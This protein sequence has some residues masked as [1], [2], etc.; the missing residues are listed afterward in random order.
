MGGRAGLTSAGLYDERMPAKPIRKTCTV[1]VDIV[2]LTV[3][4][5][6]LQI[7]LIDRGLSPFDGWPALPGGFV[8]DEDLEA[9]AERELIEETRIDATRLHLEQLQTYGAPGRDP[10]GRVVAVAYLAL[11][12]NLPVPE[13]GTDALNA[14]WTPVSDVLN[15]SIKL[16][17]DHNVIVQDGVERARSKLEYTTLATA[18]CQ[19]EFTVSEL[20]H[21][22]EIVWSTSLD[23]RNFYRKVKSAAFIIPTGQHT[24]REGGLAGAVPAQRGKGQRH[25]VP[26]H[27]E[28][29]HVNLIRGSRS[30]GVVVYYVQ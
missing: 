20:R 14:H 19:P 1:A 21:V 29:A 15:G 28:A 9:A 11:A 12:P 23:P 24:T 17:F 30:S 5:A 18:F 25:P 8:L 6:A 22:Y 3:R 7:L 26:A 2:L 10:R 13:A 16:A 4:G 27:A